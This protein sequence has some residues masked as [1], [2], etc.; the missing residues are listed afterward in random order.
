[1]LKI[2]EATDLDGAFR[3]AKTGRADAVHVLPSPFFFRRRGRLAELA[4]RH[5]LPAIYET[6][7]YVE[8]GGLM[9]YGPDFA[10]MYRRASS[11]VDRIL[12]GASPATLPIEQ[13]TRF[14]LVINGRAAKALGL[15]I[16][17][18]VLVSPTSPK[19]DS[20]MT[21]KGQA[22]Y[23]RHARRTNRSRVVAA[24]C[25]T[26]RISRIALWAGRLASSLDHAIRAELTIWPR[27]GYS[28]VW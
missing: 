12:K 27:L 17:P 3:S 9:S 2:S 13:P 8:A 1:V 28:E 7:E 26:R 5:R 10:A 14:E 18:S 11:Y 15:R 6:K 23:A 4:A 22:T 25:Q 19:R 21:S 20:G 24:F 16:P